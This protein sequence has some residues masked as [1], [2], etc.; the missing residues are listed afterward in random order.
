MKVVCVSGYFDPLHIGHVDYFFRA[1]KLGDKLV[2]IVNNDVQAAIKK[3]KAFMSAN[4]RCKII[5]ALKPVDEVYLSIDTDASVCESLKAVKPDIFAKGGDRFAHNIPEMDVIR[6]LGIE[7]V[8]GL[9]EK[10]QSSR[11][12]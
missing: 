3:G 8:D 7:L 6:E 4:E 5:E 12:F 2:V 9:G 10:L 1:K 11:N